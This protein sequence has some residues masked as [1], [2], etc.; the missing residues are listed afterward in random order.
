M[1]FN[2]LV[3]VTAIIVYVIGAVGIRVARRIDHKRAG[4]SKPAA[5]SP[6]T[7]IPFPKSAALRSR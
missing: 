1:T 7:V 4:A 3:A 2:E 6:G 5:K